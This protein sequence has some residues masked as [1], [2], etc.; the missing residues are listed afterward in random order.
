MEYREMDKLGVKVS[1]LGFGCMRLPIKKDGTIN[2]AR[3]S[4][5]IDLAYKN[6]V[7]Y[8]DTAYGYHNGESETFTGKAHF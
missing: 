8:F 4:K 1:L 3:A 7:N 2:E 6:G 5:L